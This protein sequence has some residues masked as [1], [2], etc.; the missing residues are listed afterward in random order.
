MKKSSIVNEATWVKS[1]S[2]EENFNQLWQD[3]TEL[4]ETLHELT[5]I[6]NEKL[7]KLTKIT[8]NLENKLNGIQKKGST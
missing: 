4:K 1:N 5:N 8:Q 6:Q 2:K 3:I 7:D